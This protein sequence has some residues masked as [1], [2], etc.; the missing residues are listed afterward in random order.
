MTTAEAPIRA[1]SLE[2]LASPDTPQG[3]RLEIPRVFHHKIGVFVFSERWFLLPWKKTWNPWKSTST[4]NFAGGGSMSN[5]QCV[6]YKWSKWRL[7]CGRFF[8]TSIILL[9][10]SFNLLGRIVGANVTISKHYMTP[11]LNGNKG[12]SSQPF[13]P[14]WHSP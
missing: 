4:T 7:I 13:A 9:L 12:G 14:I 8:L 5:L 1:S 3:G 6:Y 2:A 10:N 11:C